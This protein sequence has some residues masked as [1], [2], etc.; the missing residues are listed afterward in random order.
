MS[1]R[2]LYAQA[3]GGDG[4]VVGN[5]ISLASGGVGRAFSWRQD[6]GLN[7][8][9][10]VSGEDSTQA[11]GV[12]SL[13]VVA[14]VVAARNGLPQAAIWN[15]AG[16]VSLIG[17]LPGGMNWSAAFAINNNGVVVGGGNSANYSDHA[18]VWSSG[19]GM[20]D[21]Q[22][23]DS[24][25]YSSTAYGINDSGLVV[26]GGQTAYGAHA[27]LW[28]MSGGMQQLDYSTDEYTRAVGVNN[29]GSIIGTSYR[30]G[31]A[32][33][34]SIWNGA[35]AFTNLNNLV[36][37][38]DPLKGRF[39]LLTAAGINDAGN[40][41]GVGVVDGVDHAY[42]LTPVPEP[43]VR[44]LFLIGLALLVFLAGRQRSIVLG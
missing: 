23:R 24:G 6:L 8:L 5:S 14:G 27:F 29:F 18:F 26:G 35:D 38:S 31:Q 16:A 21:I 32:S 11:W 40:I 39:N 22:T 2:L 7:Y 4:S 19:K 15:K 30:W 3:I 33:W 36:D 28:S 1:G 9:L 37:E 17:D 42:F 43:K 44:V 25:F 13:G 41:V 10:G 34:A 20:L 12:N